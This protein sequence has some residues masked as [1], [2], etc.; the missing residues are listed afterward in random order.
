MS[1]KIEEIIEGFLE[2]MLNINYV[3]V[4]NFKKHMKSSYDSEEKS[5]R[6]NNPLSIVNVDRLRLEKSIEKLRNI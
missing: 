4:C 6:L 3:S 5:D 1:R 2:E